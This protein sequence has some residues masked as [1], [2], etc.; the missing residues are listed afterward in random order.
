HTRFSRDWSSDVCSSDLPKVDDAQRADAWG[1]PVEPA[2]QPFEL[3]PEIRERLS[4]VAVATISVQL[5]KRGYDTVS[6]DGVRPLV[7]GRG[8]SEERRVG[9][10]GGGGRR[11]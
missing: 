7:P 6:M 2:E 11:A 4:K 1:R 10:E 5:R 9:D 3:T 8:R